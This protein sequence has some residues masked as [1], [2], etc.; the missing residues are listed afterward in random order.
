MQ[1]P[2]KDPWPNKP[3][4][5][6]DFKYTYVY[7]SDHYDAIAKKAPL[8][9]DASRRG[10]RAYAAAFADLSAAYPLDAGR[11]S[12]MILQPFAKPNLLLS[13]LNEHCRLLAD[14]FS[15]LRQ[16]FREMALSQ[17]L[18]QIPFQNAFCDI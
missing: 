4:A 15:N 5:D 2:T 8:A 17:I 12:Y 18:E 1:W 14:F 6:F 3:G 16:N 10:F 9:A 11:F 13:S 7:E